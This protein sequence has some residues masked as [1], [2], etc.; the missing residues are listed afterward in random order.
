MIIDES[1]VA[2]ASIRSPALNIFRRDRPGCVILFALWR[3]WP[4]LFPQHGP[5]R[6]H[7][8]D[9]SLVPWQQEIADRYPG[10]L[11][12][13]LIQ[14]D[15]SR[16]LNFV[17]GK[18]YPRYQFTNNSF[19]IQEIFRRACEKIGL[20]WTQP[21]WNTLSVSRRRDVEELDAVI[22]PKR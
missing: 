21:Y 13:G 1:A 4:C 17:N 5:G 22:G 11:L 8:R 10:R 2:L 7:E 3:H 15:G 14:S 6:K 20:K 12:R 16:D 9:V 19:D 18:S